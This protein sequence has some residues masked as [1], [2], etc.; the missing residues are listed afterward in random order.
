MVGYK[1]R[2]RCAW[3]FYWSF[4]DNFEWGFGY[5]ERFGLVFVDYRTQKRIIKDSGYWY[6]TIIESNGRKLKFQEN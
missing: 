6:K 2:C 3:I 5:K 1:F 4:M